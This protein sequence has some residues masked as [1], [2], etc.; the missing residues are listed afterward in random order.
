MSHGKYLGEVIL[1]D[2]KETPYEN[3]KPSDWAVHFI[4]H[5]GQYDGDFH[6][7]WTMDQV[8]R[9]LKGVPVILKRATWEDGHSEYRFKT[10]DVT[11]EYLE[12]V[13]W[14]KGDYDEEEEEH[15]YSY[16]EGVPP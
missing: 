15:E 14:M 13:E 11:T 3:Y 12:W 5:Y 1:S 4:S 9:I 7:Q 8:V 6:K 10:G 16:D 2:Y